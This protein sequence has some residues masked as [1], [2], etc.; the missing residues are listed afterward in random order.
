MVGKVDE[1]SAG[2]VETAF[3]C[4][5]AAIDMVQPGAMYRDLGASIGKI[6]RE[7]GQWEAGGGRWQKVIWCFSC[8]RRRGSVLVFETPRRFEGSGE[9][10][11]LSF[12]FLESWVVRRICFTK[13]GRAN[14]ASTEPLF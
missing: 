11:L 1:E 4:L 5:S 14:N 13:G 7:N 10:R 3:K 6:A 8:R 9:T 2:L 12:V